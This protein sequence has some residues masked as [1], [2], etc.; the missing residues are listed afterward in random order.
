[1]PIKPENR[2]RYPSNW[3]AIRRDILE[4]ENHRCKFCGVANYQPH[5]ITG[6]RVV[7]TIAHLNHTPE[8][9]ADN[10]LAALC[11]RCHFAHDREYHRAVRA[12]T[13]RAKTKREAAGLDDRA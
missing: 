10:N 1:M 8:D 6:S 4:R 2:G 11:Q 7:L 9:C 12:A 5:P 3:K 13:L